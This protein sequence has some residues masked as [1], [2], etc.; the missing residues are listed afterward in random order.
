MELLSDFLYALLYINEKHKKINKKPK[1]YKMN[2]DAKSFKETA[3]C[4]NQVPVKDFNGKTK[5]RTTKSSIEL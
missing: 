4:F 2:S 1:L 5:Y 3:D